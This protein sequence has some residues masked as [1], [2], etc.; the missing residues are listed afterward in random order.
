MLTANGLLLVRRDAEVV[1]LD[2]ATGAQR[3]RHEI[4]SDGFRDSRVREMALT[5]DGA[6]YAIGGGYLEL[7]DVGAGPLPA[8]WAMPRA[9][10]QRSGRL[11]P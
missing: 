7:I 4:R 2:V 11:G 3:W 5:A 6:L 10:G 1:G 8:A 9:D